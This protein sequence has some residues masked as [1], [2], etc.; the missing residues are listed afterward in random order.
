[1][2]AVA[3]IV[4]SAIAVAFC[5]LFSRKGAGATS[6]MCSSRFTN[7]RL[8]KIRIRSDRACRALAG[9]PPTGRVGVTVG[10]P[11]AFPDAS[12]RTR[13]L[14]PTCP[15]TRQRA[16]STAHSSRHVRSCPA[17]EEAPDQPVCT[18]PSG[19]ITNG[20]AEQNGGTAR[21]CHN[22]R[23]APRGRQVRWFVMLNRVS[24]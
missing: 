12:V 8:V 10:I 2:I 13:G 4:L 15:S 11:S 19:E 9:T 22:K 7:L 18:Q 3:S 6:E 21:I 14:I 1:M 20:A 5:I 17:A 24:A 23:L 16:G